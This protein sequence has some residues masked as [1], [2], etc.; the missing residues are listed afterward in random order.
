ML[1]ATFQFKP[2]QPV[3]ILP[4]YIRSR[5]LIHATFQKG[6]NKTAISDLKEAGGYRLKFPKAEKCEAVIVNTGGGMAGGDH[7]HVSINVGEDANL[8]C[9]TQSAE[10]IYRS[11]SSVSLIES[12]LHLAERSHLVWIPQET[13]LF[14][15]ARLNRHLVVTMTSSAH[16]VACEMMVFGRQAMGEVLRDAALFDHWDIRRDGQLIFADRLRMCGDLQSQLMCKAVGDG[17]RS[18]ATLLYINA[19]AESRLDALRD[20]IHAYADANVEWGASAWDG[21]LSLRALSSDPSA[22]RH[23]MAQSLIY[24]NQ[25]PLPRVW[26]C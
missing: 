18:I 5:G 11:D 26:H 19:D 9:S 16:F 25:C 17:A 6:R 3:G 12:H 13:I 1:D 8:M 10:K 20:H 2:Q 15:G 23:H 4:S 22:L 24:L 21:I 14:E 7:L